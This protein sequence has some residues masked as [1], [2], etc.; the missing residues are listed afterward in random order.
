MFYVFLH[1]ME[2][3]VVF[4]FCLAVLTAVNRESGAFAGVFYFFLRAGTERLVRVVGVSAVLA[5]VPY[6]LALGVRRFVYQHDIPSAG[7]GQM[8]TGFQINVA[9]MLRDFSRLN[10][11]NDLAL[12]VAM[13][14]LPVLM[15]CGRTTL[16]PGEKKRVALAFVAIFL[17]TFQ[18]GLVREIRIFIPCLALLAAAT[19]ADWNRLR[20]GVLTCPRVFGP[21]IS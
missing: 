12:L 13:F 4:A 11:A 7:A 10:P 9:D 17:V 14:A 20:S 5:V 2:G 6:M 8:F 3:R 1:L 16:A 21:S 15:V 19:V 18:F